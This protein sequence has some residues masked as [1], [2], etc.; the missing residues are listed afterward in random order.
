MAK[1]Y[2]IVFGEN[3]LNN[4]M[5]S[6]VI[7]FSNEN[8][9]LITLLD[10]LVLGPL[11]DLKTLKGVNERVNWFEEFYQESD[12]YYQREINSID[13]AVKLSEITSLDSV[14]MWLGDDGNEYVWKAAILNFLKD[15]SISIYTVDWQNIPFNSYNG[16]DAKLFS[17]YVCTL[18]NIQLAKQYFELM[19]D[20]EKLFFEKIWEKFLINN[21]DLR[22][23]NNKNEI[24]ELDKNYFDE[25]LKSHCNPDF[26][27]SFKV[28]G[29]TIGNMYNGFNSNGIGD[30]FLIERLK[31][32]CYEG[33]LQMRNQEHGQRNGHIFEVA[34][35]N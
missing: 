5:I 17:V 7:D 25:V 26:Q 33:Q 12:F 1:E 2:H 19:T 27:F 21:S 14:Y 20:S 13:L 3:S 23:L 18:E 35:V 30:Y 28:I 22:I 24:E 32:L 15:I 16:Q 29:L 10:T 11:Y 6:D 8:I 34:L 4:L 31:Q 9:K